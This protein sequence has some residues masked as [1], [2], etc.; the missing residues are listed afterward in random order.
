M[1]ASIGFARSLASARVCAGAHRSRGDGTSRLGSWT[2]LALTL[3]LGLLGCGGDTRQPPVDGGPPTD[4]G[5][6]CVPERGYCDGRTHFVCGADGA[7]RQDEVMCESGC[8]PEDGCRPCSAGDR[9]C[10]GDV[11][12][13]CT[14]DAR[15]VVVRDCGEWGSTCGVGVCE[16]ACGEA[17][18]RRR[19]VGCELWASPLANL[20]GGG[21]L[22]PERFDFR[23]VVVNPNAE[24][25]RVA[26]AQGTRRLRDVVVGPGRLEVVVLPWIDGMSDAISTRRFESFVQPEGAY[27]IT[28]D[29][30][31]AAFQFNPFEYESE[32]TKSFTNDASLLFP[33]HA[34][35][36]D[37]VGVSYAAAGTP[38][39]QRLSGY[40]AL[41]GTTEE[42]AEVTVT[43]SAP[44]VAER[45]GAFESVAAGETLTFTLSRGEVAHLVVGGDADDDLSG[46]RIHATQPIASFG[47]HVC[48]NVTT[49]VGTCDHLET[50]L[51]P[52][53]TLGTRYAGMPLVAPRSGA[54]NLLRL[55]GAFDD[56]TVS[57]GDGESITLDAGEVHDV[58][59]DDGYSLVA[60]RP[61]LAAQFLLGAGEVE[62]RA[63]QGDPSLVALVPEEQ[64]RPDYTFVTPSSYRGG[65]GQSYVVITR[66]TGATVRLDGVLLDDTTLDDDWAAIDA[67]HEVVR[68]PVE[69]GTHRIESDE[70]VGVLVFGLGLDTS[71]AYPAGLELERIVLL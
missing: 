28:S 23:V 54:T 11:S 21:E 35:T 59:I 8:D 22:N 12:Y 40:L 47:G 13:V 32:G 20:F 41:V 24:P 17:E 69:G 50:Q 39:T 27:R 10:E 57:F 9:L 46:T 7:S 5:F 19:N 38:D 63:T 51:P 61:L 65:T 2:T 1:V 34:L 70:N 58:R 15:W 49:D 56:T 52:L 66:P 3:S 26:F 55:V 25:A 64:H 68:V 18:L 30:P 71:Y 14:E 48:A 60:S 36:G 31:I 67:M 42:A 44:I 53:Q 33:A 4:G 45:G 43:P 62:P 29:R 6:S 16:D 37:Y